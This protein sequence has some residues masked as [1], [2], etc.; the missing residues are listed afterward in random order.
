M[1]FPWIT[2]AWINL[3]G[4]GDPLDDLPTAPKETLGD[5][6]NVERVVL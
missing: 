3:Q 4:P 1:E 2:I 6:K 5:P